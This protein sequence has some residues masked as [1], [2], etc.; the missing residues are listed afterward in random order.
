MPENKNYN[1]GETS[2]SLH[3][4]EQIDSAESERKIHGLLDLLSSE[5]VHY[6]E[7]QLVIFDSVLMS[8]ITRLENDALAKISR[9]AAPIHRIPAGFVNE[10]A[11]HELAKI[12]VP[13]LTQNPV[14]SDE[15]LERVAHERSDDH[16]LA[17]SKRENVP[18]S[19]CDILIDRGS[20]IVLISLAENDGAN[21]SAIAFQNLSDMF[22]NNL[23]VGETLCCRSDIPRDVFIKLIRLASDEARIRI[24]RRLEG[25]TPPPLATTDLS[26]ASSAV[27]QATNQILD[28]T[29]QHDIDY[30]AARKRLMSLVKNKQLTEANFM[31]LAQK[32]D[33]E[34]LVVAFSIALKLNVEVVAR[35]LTENRPDSAIILM[36]ALDFAWPTCRAVLFVRA[37]KTKTKL[38]LEQCAA[39][40]GRITRKLAEGIIDAQRKQTH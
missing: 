1:K 35:H 8:L 14:V 2:S 22:Q 31:E 5:D 28:Q 17:I 27:T 39:S 25:A 15:T 21:L 12:A 4:S 40:H 11:Y 32:N 37:E 19:V 23:P 24:R 13:V 34:A 18:T 3:L 33:F 38:E 36:R 10:I 7:E 26:T 16:L 9:R 20:E 6:S 30:N 29:L